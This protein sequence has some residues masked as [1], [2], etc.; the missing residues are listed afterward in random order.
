MISRYH[1]SSRA[2]GPVALDRLHVE[3]EL[4]LVPVRTDISDDVA[5]THVGARDQL[6]R[7]LVHRPFSRVDLKNLIGPLGVFDP[8]ALNV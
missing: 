4:H 8:T 3:A 7:D 1:R 5:S 2:S 6:G